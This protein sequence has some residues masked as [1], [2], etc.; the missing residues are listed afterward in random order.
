ML[1]S[2]HAM[3]G[4]AS[5]LALASVHHA[6]P[7]SALVLA[8]AAGIGGL[9]PDMDHRGSMI[10]RRLPFLVLLTFWFPHRTITHSLAV[11][12]LI[13]AL[14]IAAQ[15]IQGIALVTGYSLHIAADM[16]TRRG[17]ALFYPLEA[18]AYLLPRPLRLNTGGL[19]E[20]LIAA[21]VL[22]LVMWQF[23]L[24]VK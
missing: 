19:L 16:L 23:W 4:V 11:V 2:T 20:A 21:A 5:G 7:E 1:G 8:V 24:M 17:V 13:S 10:N 15:S 9:L 6:T 18:R 14:A 3:I 22:L 12:L